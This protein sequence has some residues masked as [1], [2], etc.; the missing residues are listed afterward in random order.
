EYEEYL[1]TYRSD[2][3]Y[4]SEVDERSP[5]EIADSLL[6]VVAEKIDLDAYDELIEYFTDKKDVQKVLELHDQRIEA[7]PSYI[8]Y[9]REKA[10]YLREEKMYEEGIETLKRAHTII[11]YNASTY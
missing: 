11:P 9:L 7:Y 2:Y 6:G 3:K 4:R 5:G 1:E 8:Y 10:E